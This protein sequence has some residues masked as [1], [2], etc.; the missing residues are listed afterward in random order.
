LQVRDIDGEFRKLLM[1]FRS[2]TK[3][4]WISNP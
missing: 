3:D 1:I 2:Y 4:V